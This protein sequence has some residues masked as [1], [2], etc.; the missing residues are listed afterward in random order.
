MRSH[1]FLDQ[2][3]IITKIYN[4]EIITN[5][6]NNVYNTAGIILFV[7]SYTNAKQHS[8]GIAKARMHITYL[9]GFFVYCPYTSAACND[10]PIAIIVKPN[11]FINESSFEI[12]LFFI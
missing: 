7:N 6:N 11:L 9:F 2:K 1:L 10:I 4:N 8:N 12:I 5:K 3:A